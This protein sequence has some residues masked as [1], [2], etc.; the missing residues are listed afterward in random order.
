MIRVYRYSLRRPHDADAVIQQMRAAHDYANDLTAI[1][2]G[3]RAAMRAI[4]DRAD[5]LRQLEDAVRKATKSDLMAARMALAKARRQVL[6]READEVARIQELDGSIRR[7][8][9]ALTP[10][11][12]GTYLMVEAAA[13]AARRAPLYGDDMLTPHDPRFARWRDDGAIGVQIQGGL[14]VSELLACSS[15]RAR[16]E[17]HPPRSASKTAQKERR[18]TLRIRI[19][20]DGRDPIWAELPMLY[21]RRMPDAGRI[22]WIRVYRTQVG[23]WE[24]WYCTMTVEE[25]GPRAAALDKDRRGV[26]AV[27]TC[28]EPVG[29]TIRVARWRDDRG[30]SGE[31]LLPPDVLARAKKSSDLQALRDIMRNDL[32][33]ALVRA[34]P[35]T[36]PE[37]LIHARSTLPFWRSARRY[38][39]IA[40][41]VRADAS[42]PEPVRELLSAWA[43]RDTHLWQYQTGT[44]GDA[45]ERRTYHY[46]C[47]AAEWSRRYRV[48]LLPDRDLRYQARF[49]DDGDARFVASP[50]QLERRCRDTFAVVVRHGRCNAEDDWIATAIER[51]SDEIAAAIDRAAA[52][53]DN[54]AGGA[55]ARRKKA[56]RERAERKP[57]AETSQ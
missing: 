8:A 51:A 17:V 23:P 54:T 15:S 6:D 34:I 9:R 57:A 26:L 1:E 45:I 31:V 13:D 18:A 5:E 49:G 4:Y 3:R 16:L 47:L 27:Q 44:R 38:H 24:R 36:A 33:S 43:Y 46:R 32:T 20:S 12:W 28:W 48:L 7:D 10:C 19:G 37:Y 41:R 40:K 21:H 53:Q 50:S 2:R 42:A 29:D 56:K 35:D 25:P 30:E 52:P 11:Y 39:D 55:W 14:A 22:K